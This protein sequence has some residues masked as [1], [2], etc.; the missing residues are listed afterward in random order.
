MTVR[1]MVAC[2][3]R[4]DPLKFNVSF[5]DAVSKFTGQGTQ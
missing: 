4:N 1:L 5:R 3:C 2:L